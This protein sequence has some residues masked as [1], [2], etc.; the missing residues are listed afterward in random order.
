[1]VPFKVLNST[2]IVAGI[3]DCWGLQQIYVAF[4]SD[5][6]WWKREIVISVAKALWNARDT[7]SDHFN[8]K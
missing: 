4:S 7:I 5:R 1:M 8:I 6:C 2:F 3:Q